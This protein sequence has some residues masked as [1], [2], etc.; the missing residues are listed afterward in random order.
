MEMPEA[1]RWSPENAMPDAS[2]SWMPIG[3]HAPDGG[4]HVLADLV[5]EGRAQFVGEIELIREPTPEEIE[6]DERR[7][8]RAKR[9]QRNKKLKPR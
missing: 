8:R 6:R 4:V 3:R 5:R 7:G 1:S 9:L 2:P